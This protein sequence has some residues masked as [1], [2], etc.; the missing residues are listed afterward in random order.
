VAALVLGGAVLVALLSARSYA[1]NWNDGSR[2]ATVECLVEYHT[3]VIDHSIFVAVPG[4][5]THDEEEAEAD[6]KGARSSC[7]YLP[8]AKNLVEGGTLDKLYINGHY[9]SDKSPVPA[10]WLA[11]VYQVWRWCAGPSAG[12]RPDWFCYLMT[13]VSSGLGYVLTVWC[14]YRLG[15]VLGL[16]L[17]LRLLLTASLALATVALPYSQ[18]V[19]NHNL[20]LGVVAALVL[21]LALLASEPHWKI[22]R[23]AVVG[24]LV[25]LGYTIDLGAGPVLFASTLAL[26]A[27]RSWRRA[28]TLWAPCHLVTLSAFLLGATPWLLLHHA[29]NYA[30]G[31]T[32]VPANAVAEYFRWPGCPFT[33]ETM[34][35]GWKHEGLGSFLLYAVALLVGKRGFLVYNLP[36]LLAVLA[37]VSLLRRRVAEWPELLW[38][39]AWAGGTWLL[40]AANSN[41][42]SGAC[43]SIRWFVPL[44][45]PGY[46]VLAVW[47]KHHPEGKIPLLL[48]SV[49]A[50]VLVV[51]MTRRGPWDDH[52]PHFLW[53]TVAL[54]VASWS[55][56]E[57]WRLRR[58]ARSAE[59]SAGPVS[60]AV[61]GHFSI[62]TE[63]E[64]RQPLDE[65][66]AEA[67]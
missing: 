59:E 60:I 40:Y 67:K 46:L 34:T 50:G 9:Y 33:P 32:L 8:W 16:S 25:G 56:Y 12:E 20:L 43:C 24:T 19:N 39:A 4:T 66:T 15:G 6:E 52:L 23:I 41:N 26:V 48:L 13:L 36:L 37:V 5:R 2:L 1:G 62:P 53:P 18:F 29:L 54:A 35:G 64:R 27:Y 45:A 22:W 17:P 65:S 38:A 63:L 31:G 14:V 21:N 55:G 47:L 58:L 10:L 30:V 49:W 11:G 3:F 28:G 57:W 51:T 61:A 42:Y 7:P 44:L